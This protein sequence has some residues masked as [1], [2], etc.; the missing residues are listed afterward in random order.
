MPGR[1]VVV[2]ALEGGI[3]DVGFAVL[4]PVLGLWGGISIGDS[5]GLW[6]RKDWGMEMGGAYRRFPVL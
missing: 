4:A 3:A 5:G 6:R 2:G 1:G